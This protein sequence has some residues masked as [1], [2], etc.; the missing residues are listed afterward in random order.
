MDAK[1]TTPVLRLTLTDN[2]GAPK[3]LVKQLDR[4]DSFLWALSR[5]SKCHIRTHSGFDFKDAHSHHEV[6]IPNDEVERFWE[7]WKTFT[8]SDHWRFKHLHYENW[9]ERK[10]NRSYI[11][12]KHTPVE[13]NKCPRRKSSCRNGRCIHTAKSSD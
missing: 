2:R 4:Y 13:W 7:R 1:E 11:T 12:E 9:D 6:R 3:N 10:A 5:H 8:P